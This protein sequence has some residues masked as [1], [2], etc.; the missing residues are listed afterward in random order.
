[1]SPSS[2]ALARVALASL[3]F[4]SFAGC[5]GGGLPTG[6]RE[7]PDGDGPRIV[8][9][10]YSGTLPVIPLPN[11]VATWPDPSSPT[12]M[13]INASTLVPTGLES[14]TRALFD[15]LAWRRSGLVSRRGRRTGF[16]ARPG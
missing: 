4:V 1:M 16:P 8:W 12:G 14:R 10:L 15:E 13:R 5:D 2:R 6:W 3:L 7:T 11:D 9:D